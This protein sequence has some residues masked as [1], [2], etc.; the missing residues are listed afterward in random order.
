MRAILLIICCLP[1]SLS[2]LWAETPSALISRAVFFADPSIVSPRISPDGRFISYLALDH[3]RVNLWVAPTDTP[4]DAK[5]L[6]PDPQQSVYKYVWSADSK[7]LV[8]QTGKL[9]DFW[10]D[11]RDGHDYALH[12]VDVA[13]QNTKRLTEA[14]SRRVK[15]S[16]AACCR[17]KIFL[18]P[19][20]RGSDRDI[21]IL[22]IET[23]ENEASTWNEGKAPVFSDEGLTPR[24]VQQSGAT[25]GIEFHTKA[26]NG[27]WQTLL[28]LT[29]AE[30][31]SFRFFGFSKAGNEAFIAHAAHSD[32]NQLYAVNPDTGAERLLAKEGEGEIDQIVRDPETGEPVAVRYSHLHKR[33]AVLVPAWEPFF[34]DLE[35]AHTGDIAILGHTADGTKW[36]IEYSGGDNPGSYYLYDKALRETRFLFHKFAGYSKHAFPPMHAVTLKARDGLELA[37]YL[38]LPKGSD[39]DNDGVPDRPLPLVMW[40]HGGPISRGYGKFDEQAQWLAARSYAVLSMNFRGSA[41]FG[42]HFIEAGYSQWG[43]AMQTDLLD[44]ANWAIEKGITEK[45][46]IALLGLSYGGYATLNGL[47]DGPNLFKCGIATAALSDLKL[48][49]DGIYSFIS[50]V[51]DP[52]IKA[53]FMARLDRDAMQMGGDI[54]TETGQTYLTSISP[55][56]RA[57]EI[58]QP[59]M[60]VDGMQDAAVKPIHSQLITKA[61]KRLG[62]TPAYITFSDAGHGLIKKANIRAF[63]AQA[64]VFLGACLGGEVEAASEAERN[65]KSMT[66]NEGH[67]LLGLDGK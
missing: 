5:A 55:L 19:S 3:D 60:I 29:S 24:F 45:G 34:K 30:R 13:G 33:W 17:E 52:G 41:G 20:S 40:V 7:K 64:E 42:K 57:A 66:I 31:I 35:A 2:A 54:R 43:K 39:S 36:L 6:I 63:A 61:L 53:E 58:V 12:V 26:Q 14:L 48:F 50:K 28:D 59:L 18:N 46:N 11:N 51:T 62:R 23:G 4:E 37:A 15:F 27:R 1:I 21:R 65:H 32:R 10:L 47:A 25:G 56:H 16:T 67:A 22:N 9:I 49:M 8:Y 38:T 44:T